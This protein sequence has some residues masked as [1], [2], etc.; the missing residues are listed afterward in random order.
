MTLKKFNCMFLFNLVKIFS[1]MFL[2]FGAEMALVTCSECGSKVS[3][4]ADSCPSCGC[5]VSLMENAGNK[6]IGG[7]VEGETTEVLS[8]GSSPDGSESDTELQQRPIG[9]GELNTISAPDAKSAGS[10]EDSG[11]PSRPAADGATGKQKKRGI[12]KTI[13]VVVAVILLAPTLLFVGCL[14]TAAIFS[15]YGRV[16]GAELTITNNDGVSETIGANELKET[17]AGNE[18]SAKAKYANAPVEFTDSIHEV[19]GKSIYNGWDLHGFIETDSG[20]VVEYSSAD[21]KLLSTLKAGDKI[22]VKGKIT[23]YISA[24]RIMVLNKNGNENIITKAD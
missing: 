5:P 20:L 15:P 6:D 24:R 11:I 21:E 13:A 14:G 1:G 3:D 12:G 8:V 23:T 18:V 16:G 4:K 10:G 17:W 19:K 2:G 9:D 7:A 22:H